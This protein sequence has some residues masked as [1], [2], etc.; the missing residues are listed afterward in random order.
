MIDRNRK[1]FLIFAAIFCVA[2]VVTIASLSLSSCSKDR[3]FEEL[4]TDARY[5]YEARDFE[6]CVATVHEALEIES[7]PELYL[8]LADAYMAQ[9]NIDSAIEWL[10]VGSYKHVSSIIETKLGELKSLKSAGDDGSFIE[11]GG[12]KF[13]ILAK[14]MTLS[15]GS[16]SDISILEDLTTLETLTLSDNAISDLTPLGSLTK[17]TY[18][19]LSGNRAD[20]ITAIGKLRNLRTL[21]L[22]GNP[23]EDFTPLYSLR[24]LRS[25]SVRDIGLTEKQLD[26]LKVALPACHINHD[27]PKAAAVELTLGGVTFMSDVKELSLIS[28]GIVDLT[29]LEQC[30]SL[31]KLDLSH[32]AIANLAPLAGLHRLERLNL[33]GNMVVDITPLSGLSS[34]KYLTLDANRVQSLAPL[35]ASFSI[36]ELWLSYNNFNDVSP[37]RGLHSLARLGLKGLGLKDAHLEDLK[38][39][40]SLLELALDENPDLTMDALNGLK[41]AL[42]SCLISH[43]EAFYTITLGDFEFR[44]DTTNISAPNAGVSDISGLSNFKSL[45]SL[46]LPGNNISN[47]QTLSGLTKLEMLDLGNNIG[48]TNSVTDLS[49]LTALTALKSLSLIRNGVADLG[50]LSGLRSLTELHLSFNSITNISALGQLSSLRTLSL[51]YNQISDIGSLAALTALAELDLEGNRIFDLS[52]LYGLEGLRIL[53]IG[54]NGISEEALETLRSHLPNCAIYADAH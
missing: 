48:G 17:L 50:A 28:L 34:L 4:I 49:P 21:Y 13:D 6:K 15:P 23:V 22:D 41:Q 3:R 20:D 14:S 1:G 25:L 16:V 12:Q 37:L 40:T 2:V 24:E 11:L 19:N 39:I 42:Y 30:D 46:V 35:S 45:Q 47:V 10:Y 18:L 44:S 5:L 26:D 29:V 31:T 9:D 38:P 43:S 53:Y 51:S 27:E 52:P 8:L 32:N 7:Q 54:S 36:E 33:T